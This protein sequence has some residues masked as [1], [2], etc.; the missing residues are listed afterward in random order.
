MWK[1]HWSTDVV[2]NSAIQ[3]NCHCQLILS[4]LVPHENKIKLQNNLQETCPEN[5]FI[6]PVVHTCGKH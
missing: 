5:I 3:I 4:V 2:F 1:A 6:W